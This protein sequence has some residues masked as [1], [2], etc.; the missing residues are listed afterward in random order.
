MAVRWYIAPPPRNCSSVGGGEGV[1]ELFYLYRPVKGCGRSS[2]WLG[3]GLQLPARDI[4][5]TVH[6]RYEL[7]EVSVYHGLFTFLVDG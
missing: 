5:S 3:M 1:A 7:L 2:R 6:H 4:V